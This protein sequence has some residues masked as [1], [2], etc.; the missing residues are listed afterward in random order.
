MLESFPQISRIY[1]HPHLSA[2][3]H[4]VQYDKQ[5]QRTVYTVHLLP[6]KLTKASVGGGGGAGGGGTG[7]VER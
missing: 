6:V 5:Q 7:M 4:P 1:A 2:S 3:G